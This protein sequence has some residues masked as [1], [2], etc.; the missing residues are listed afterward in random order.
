L[1]TDGVVRISSRLAEID[2][3]TSKYLEA[4]ARGAHFSQ[5]ILV[6]SSL[7][8]H[9]IDD[10]SLLTFWAGGDPCTVELTMRA[11]DDCRSTLAEALA[12]YADVAQASSSREL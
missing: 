11:R 5:S 6:Q 9:C 2:N 12:V 3:T 4:A 1:H 7:D 10:S 8:S